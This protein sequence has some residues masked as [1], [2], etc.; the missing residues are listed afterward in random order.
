M[1][2]QWAH[3]I[4]LY[5]DS[6]HNRNL[7]I[8]PSIPQLHEQHCA[9][10]FL[11]RLPEMSMVTCHEI[12]DLRANTVLFPVYRRIAIPRNIH[13]NYFFPQTKFFNFCKLDTCNF[14]IKQDMCLK[15]SIFKISAWKLIMFQMMFHINQNLNFLNVVIIYSIYNSHGMTFQDSH[16][17][18]YPCLHRMNPIHKSNLYLWK[19]NHQP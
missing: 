15:F 18:K 17:P 11:K 16:H 13:I 4:I 14:H 2:F 10:Q 8:R 19:I 3:Y 5:L 9:I 7:A 1:N 12:H 6:L